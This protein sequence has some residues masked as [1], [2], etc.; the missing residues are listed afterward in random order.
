MLVAVSD[1][2]INKVFAAAW[3]KAVRR[4]P[5]LLAK[6]ESQMIIV[7]VRER[8]GALL[9]EGL[10]VREVRDRIVDELLDPDSPIYQKSH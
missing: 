7:R 2:L 3:K 9:A 5:V 6:H 8:I 4:N 1:E 10:S